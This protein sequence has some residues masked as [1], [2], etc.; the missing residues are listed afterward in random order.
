MPLSELADRPP[1]IVQGRRLQGARVL[2]LGYGREGASAARYL[3]GEGARVTV[4]DRMINA[5]RDEPADGPGLIALRPEDVTLLEWSDLVLVSP[6]I[7]DNNPLLQEA[8]DRRLPI[9]SATELFFRCCPCKIVGVTGSSGKSTT[10]ALIGDI[11][12]AAGR[13]T[14]VGGNIG[15]PMLDLLPKLTAASVAVVELSS[16]QLQ[17]LNKSPGVAVVTNI[18]RN[19]LDRHGDMRSYVAAK[20]N[21]IAHQSSSDIA[22]LNAD[23]PILDEWASD[24]PGWARLFGRERRENSAAYVDSHRIVVATARGAEP[25]IPLAA[26]PLPGKHNLQNAL[27][28]VAAAAAL[29]IGPREMRQAIEVFKG[30]PHRL[31][32]VA[33]IEGVTF[34]DDSIATT[35]ERAAVGLEAI[36]GPVVL[37]AGGRSKHLSW[38]PLLAA[39]GSKVHTVVLFGEAAGEIE[40]ALCDSELSYRTELERRETMSEAVDLGR[41]RAAVGDTVLLSPGCTSY[42]AFSNYEERGD[43]FKSLVEGYRGGKG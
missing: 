22:I 5:P 29:S 19:H 20:R 15:I 3:A 35:P 42:D 18:G 8:F 14:H 25:V 33:R 7:A 28:A 37:L 17:R 1:S 11:L 34:V 4:A 12:L 31:Q 36:D 32:P 6:G 27:A 40:D 21:A 26:I 23:D 10:T 43:L 13:D 24:A 2:V 16:F 39:M 9:T 41:F 38:A 30:L